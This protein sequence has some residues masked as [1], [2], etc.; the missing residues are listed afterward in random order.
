MHCAVDAVP[1]CKATPEKKPPTGWTRGSGRRIIVGVCARDKKAR[2]KA[3]TEIL[4]RLDKR[5][6]EVRGE[7]RK[8]A[9]MGGWAFVKGLGLGKTA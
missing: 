5:T 8:G 7:P 1:A 4:S 3:M 9:C 6:F 2:S